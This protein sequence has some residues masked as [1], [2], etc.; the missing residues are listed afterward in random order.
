MPVH[1]VAAADPAPSGCLQLYWQLQPAT[2]RLTPAVNEQLT[3]LL[4]YTPTAP[5]EYEAL[6]SWKLQPSTMSC[7]G[8]K[9]AKNRMLVR[10]ECR[11]LLSKQRQKCWNMWP[12]FWLYLQHGG[13]IASACTAGSC[14]DV[15]ETAICFN[16]QDSRVEF[17]LANM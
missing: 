11:Y 14:F 1:A 3:S 6:F 2:W 9:T 5:S 12:C 4:S 13:G 8:T 10:D 7:I 15:D 16:L 17:R